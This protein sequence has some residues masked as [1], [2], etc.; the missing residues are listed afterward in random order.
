MSTP[1]MTITIQ[2]INRAVY[3]KVVSTQIS[4]T[5][6]TF[7]LCIYCLFHLDCDLWSFVRLFNFYSMKMSNDT[8]NL[9]FKYQ[10]VWWFLTIYIPLSRW[11]N[12][13]F[14]K[15]TFFRSINWIFVMKMPTKTKNHFIWKINAKINNTDTWLQWTHHSTLYTM[16]TEDVYRFTE[17]KCELNRT[18]PFI[19]THELF[20]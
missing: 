12:L 2:I 10:I 16:K 11:S 20:W 4:F 9:V 1:K 13:L 3:R 15:I 18:I 17:R 7:T 19:R 6:V 5:F 14:I 8:I